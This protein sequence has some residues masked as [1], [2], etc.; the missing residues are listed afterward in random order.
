M[1]TELN[2]DCCGGIA[3]FADEAGVFYVGQPL[4]CGCSGY[5]VFADDGNAGIYSECAFKSTPFVIPNRP[6]YPV[7]YVPETGLYKKTT[8]HIRALAPLNWYVDRL[9]AEVFKQATK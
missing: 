1:I 7:V 9:A 4:W 5:V 6:S 8:A 3:A 2:C